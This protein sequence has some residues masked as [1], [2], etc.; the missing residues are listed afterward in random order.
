MVSSPGP[1][2]GNIL[3]L[4]VLKVRL[5]IHVVSTEEAECH[6][7]VSHSDGEDRDHQRFHEAVWVRLALVGLNEPGHCATSCQ[8]GYSLKYV[9][10][11]LSLFV[12]F[13]FD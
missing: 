10:F 8:I 11:R 12:P 3:P 1:E 13:D 4:V 6:Q 5:P 7:F 2:L 9:V